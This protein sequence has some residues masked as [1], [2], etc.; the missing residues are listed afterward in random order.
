MVFRKGIK[1]WNKG[2]ILNEEGRK[3]LSN[4]HLGQKAW[5]KGIN[6]W[7][8]KIHPRGMKGKTNKWGNH[9][10]S[11]KMKIS[12]TKK[13]LYKKGLIIP[14]NKGKKLSQKIK[15]KISNSKIKHFKKE[16]I[17]CNKIFKPRSENHKLCSTECFGV[18]NSGK[19]NFL[20]K[21]G[22]SFEIYPKE[23]R[24][25]RK[26]IRKRDKNICKIC[27]IHEQY[28]KDKLCVHHLDENKLNISKNNLISVCRQCHTRI[29]RRKK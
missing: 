26:I 16:C 18:W 4:S 24:Q 22:K 28:L 6:M 12:R 25:I 29:H 3:K 21:G 17:V 19:N 8:N 7:K 15:L 5:N 23:W 1:P 9:T 11:S 13:E 20:W 14:H 2:K 10:K 27:G